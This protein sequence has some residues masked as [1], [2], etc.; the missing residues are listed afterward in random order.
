MLPRVYFGFATK[1]APLTNLLTEKS[2]TLQF[3]GTELKAFQNPKG[4][5][6]IV[7]V[8]KVYDVALSIRV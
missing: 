7:L 6:T 2:S 3:N 8:L 4:Q 1:A 5:L